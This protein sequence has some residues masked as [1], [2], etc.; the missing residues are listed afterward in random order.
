MMPE[1]SSNLSGDCSSTSWQQTARSGFSMAI[2]S[3]LC[4][5]VSLA[6]E[7]LVAY[8]LGA[9]T[10]TD[11]YA[12][13]MLIPGFATSL[14]LQSARSSFLAQ[15]PLQRGR[16]PAAEREFIA[17]YLMEI[18]LFCLTIALISY[19]VLSYLWPYLFPLG[20]QEIR[21][22]AMRMLGPACGL[23]VTYGWVTALTA[24][25]NAHRIFVAPQLTTLIPTMSVVLWILFTPGEIAYRALV[26]GLFYGS[27][28]QALMLLLYA[29]FWG[30]SFWGTWAWLSTR[31]SRLWSLA[32]PLILSNVSTQVNS[33]VDRMMAQGLESGAV[34]ILAWSGMLRDLVSGTLLGGFVGVLLPHFAEQLAARRW[35]ESGAALEQI[36]R[37]G[38]WLVLPSSAVLMTAAVLA[39]GQLRFGHLDQRNMAMLGACFAAYAVGFYGELASNTLYQVLIALRRTRILLLYSIFVNLMPNIVF[40]LLLIVPL[41]AVGLALSTSLVAYCTLL[42]NYAAVCRT[43]PLT[44]HVILRSLGWAISVSLLCGTA[45]WGAGVGAI[46][47]MPD[48]TGW[49]AALVTALAAVTAGVLTFGVLVFAAYIRGGRLHAEVGWLN[50]VIFRSH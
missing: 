44:G 30:I 25:L 36:L 26:E 17:Q 8:V 20:S 21:A 40:N 5:L 19:A 37:R 39:S 9:G 27:I 49:I 46:V 23:V 38:A 48:R 32:I 45:A 42:A 50:H 35:R 11:A 16:N 7:L 28:V 1:P 31:N 22:V 47:L 33:Y 15:Y 18:T 41:G 14:F 3:L 6:K 24:V 43:V 34:A 4:R 2:T 13:V 12:L 29:N 10:I